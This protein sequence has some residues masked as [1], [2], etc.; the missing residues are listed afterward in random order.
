M[1]T[2]SS[3]NDEGLKVEITEDMVFE[4]A[5]FGNDC[6]QNPAKTVKDRTGEKERGYGQIMS[7]KMYGKIYENEKNWIIWRWP[8]SPAI[9]S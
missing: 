3:K 1:T 5:K 7:D 9:S 2:N 4:A 6:Y 8:T